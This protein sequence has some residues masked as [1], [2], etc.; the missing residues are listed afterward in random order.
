MKAI[1]PISCIA[2]LFSSTIAYSACEFDQSAVD[3][4]ISEIETRYS[5]QFEDRRKAVERE[6]DQLR[7][8]APDPNEV[9]GVLGIEFEVDWSE[10]EFSL[11]V[12]EFTMRDQEMIFDLPSVAMRQQ[13]WIY[14]TPSVRMRQQCINNPPETVCTMRQQ[15]I[16]GGW[17][18]IC[19]DIPE[20][21]M[22]SGGQTCTDLPET[23]MQEQRTILHVPE[24]RMERQRIV[25]GIPEVSMGLQTIK[26]HLPEFKVTDIS[27][28]VNE[29][30]QRGEQIQEREQNA[31][32]ALSQSMAGEIRAVSIDQTNKTFDCNREQLLAQRDAGL[33]EI[34]ININAVNGSL[35]AAQDSGATEIASAMTTA[36]DQLIFAK[37]EAEQTFNTA[38]ENLET[39]RREA[40]T[41]ISNPQ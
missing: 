30:K 4:E 7:E 22:R 10:Q 8:E 5:Q 18:R 40:I 27:V 28:E 11:H 12:P 17:S 6:T 35:K 34:D 24:V 19:T 14:H 16:G 13:T 1:S 23:F 38:L 36:L 31:S 33:S 15:C 9:E 39:A 3:A 2:L 41:K 25:L 20:C 37:S 29:L 26:M 32:E 21:K